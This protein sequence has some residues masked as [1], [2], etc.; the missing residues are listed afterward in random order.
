MVWEY[1]EK[2]GYKPKKKKKP[3]RED[4]LRKFEAI[5]EDIKYHKSRKRILNLLFE[6]FSESD[7]R[8]IVVYGMYI[9][10][11]LAPF[12]PTSRDRRVEKTLEWLDEAIKF[13][14]ENK[15]KG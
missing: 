10:K 11:N 1:L 12:I 7:P 9:K 6:G 14:M 8:E 2:M 15:Q 13:L 5:L 4:S 3:K